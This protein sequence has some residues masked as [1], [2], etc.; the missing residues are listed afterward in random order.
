MLNWKCCTAALSCLKYF[1]AVEIGGRPRIATHGTLLHWP[2]G[3][4]TRGPG[5][6]AAEIAPDV[7]SGSR[8]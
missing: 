5:V 8:P 4:S 7:V 1:Q 6:N 3:D 2:G